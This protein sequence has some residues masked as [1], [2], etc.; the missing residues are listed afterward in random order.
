MP[1]FI[2]RRRDGDLAI[3]SIT[4]LASTL[5]AQNSW[6]QPTPATSPGSL[7]IQ[8]MV[9]DSARGRTVMFGGWPTIPIVPL[10]NETWEWTGTTWT[11]RTTA[12]A[13]S[14]RSHTK[15]AY[16]SARARVVLFGGYNFGTPLGDTW[17]FDGFNWQ[18]RSPATNPPPNWSA[19]L[20]FDSNRNVTVMFGGRT[21]TQFFDDTWEWD[22]TDWSLQVPANRPQAR[23]DFGMAFDSTRNVAVIHRGTQGATNTTFHDDL[24]EWDGTDWTQVPTNG[25]LPPRDW[26]G[27]LIYHPSRQRLV[28]V[29]H[30]MADLQTWTFAGSRWQRECFDTQPSR[31]R[32]YQ[33]AYDGLRDRVVLYGGDSA[34][35]SQSTYGATWLLDISQPPPLAA[36]TPVGTGCA[37]PAG[38]P[39]L[40]ANN[41]PTHGQDCVI[42]LG[43]IAP[44]VAF[45]SLGLSDTVWGGIPLPAGLGTFGL[46]PSCTA[47]SSVDL[48]VLGVA[49][50]SGLDLTAPIPCG[51]A[52]LEFF[53]QGA[54]M[55]ITATTSVPLVVSNSLRLTVGS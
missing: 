2:N 35:P 16:D 40:T 3:L 34:N 19:G 50:T 29:F 39:T 51:M 12:V 24:W 11:Q 38:I 44:G 4:L 5:P 15:L 33:V 13:P 49:G 53:V 28:A 52:G 48:S 7:T 10:S 42:H 55:D 22:G 36:V 9:Y 47:Y 46:D 21:D 18:Q 37:G 6:T 32:V 41:P 25:P 30:H 17:E 8:G 23:A 54:S 27:S 43:N 20:V 45:F 31:R 14:P 1:A 26:N